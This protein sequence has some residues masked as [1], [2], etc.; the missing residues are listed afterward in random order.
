[1]ARK[2]VITA[3]DL[4]T[5]KCTTAI[6][7][8]SEDKD[9]RVAGVGIASSRGMRKS[10]IVDLE[11]VLNTITE[12][13]DKAERMAGV[14]IRGAYLSVSGSHIKSINSK[15]V[16]AV[17]QP[18]QE[19]S[20]Y[21]VSRVI[22]AARAISL[23][24]DTRIIHVIPRDFKV[25]SQDGIKDP[26]GMTGVRLE[27]E[28]HIITGT[29]TGLRNL[30]KCV[31][32][33]DL[34]VDAFVFSALAASEVVLTETEKELGVVLVDI[35]A[36]STSLCAYVEGSLDYSGSVLIGA[37]HITQDIALG[38]RISL[39]S[40]EKIKLELSK[41][42]APTIESRS[43]ETK[44]DLIKRRKQAD[45]LDLNKLNISEGVDELSRRAVAEGI[46]TPRIREIFEMIKKTLVE[47]NLMGKVPAGLV[48]TGGGAETSMIVEVARRTMKLPVRIGEP[49]RLTGLSNEISSPAFATVVGLLAFGMNQGGGKDISTKTSFRSPLKFINFDE[50]K[51]K[52]MQLFKSIIP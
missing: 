35:G 41:T 26:V 10:S 25:D 23:P 33:L 36:G 1:M 45:K 42:A 49:K 39:D 9:I 32:D 13:V 47:N 29:K 34:N 2:K 40:A 37:R 27:S 3:I 28:A 16:V 7:T 31:N 52:L 51:N 6:A 24:S 14:D 38:C 44:E 22:E 15:G 18:D 21:D 48:L 20:D 50:L 17:A 30:E 8:V 43:G 46:M 5:E 4:G 11:Q 19:I 12:S